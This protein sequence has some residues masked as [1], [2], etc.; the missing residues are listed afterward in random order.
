MLAYN[1]PSGVKDPSSLNLALVPMCGSSVLRVFHEYRS[2]YD[3]AS[4][5]AQA[6]VMNS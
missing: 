6:S 3:R 4:R 5:P 1:L 2:T